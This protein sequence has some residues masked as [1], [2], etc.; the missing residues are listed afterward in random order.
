M[1]QTKTMQQV[2]AWS[3]IEI[4]SNGSIGNVRQDNLTDALQTKTL[5]M[6]EYDMEV[7]VCADDAKV[8]VHR[9]GIVCLE[10]ERDIEINSV[11]ADELVQAVKKDLETLMQVI[12]D[13]HSD[14]KFYGCL[15][16]ADLGRLLC[17]AEDGLTVLSKSVKA[18]DLEDYGRICNE[19]RVFI[20]KYRGVSVPEVLAGEKQT[21]E[22]K[23]E[24]VVE[25][26]AES[27]VKKKVAVKEKKVETESTGDTRVLYINKDGK[28]IIDYA[29]NVAGEQMNLTR[30]EVAELI[31]AGRV[32]NATKCIS[33][34]KI[35]I[36]IKD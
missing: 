3:G 14:V 22:K 4:F 23:D 32:V 35:Y 11:Q 15:Y 18:Y 8:G 19:Q 26:E 28:H 9:N 33:R 29:C 16:F 36:Q 6:E 31:D 27:V 7:L 17:M 34:G 30:E 21:E 20:C 5:K 1:D 12:R 24:S 2:F 10:F 13:A 25:K